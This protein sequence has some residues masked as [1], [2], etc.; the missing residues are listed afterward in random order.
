MNKSLFWITLNPFISNINFLFSGI[1][2]VFVFFR[3]VISCITCIVSPLFASSNALFKSIYSEFV[4]KFLATEINFKYLESPSL[5]TAYPSS[6]SLTDPSI[7][8]VPLNTPS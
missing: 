2:I 7:G 6:T 1:S 8:V 3:V 4:V 5:Y